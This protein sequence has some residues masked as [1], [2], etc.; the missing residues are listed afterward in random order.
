MKVLHNSKYFDKNCFLVPNSL[1][2][3]VVYKC[4]MLPTGQD[5]KILH[6]RN[7]SSPAATACLVIGDAVEKRAMEVFGEADS[8]GYVLDGNGEMVA[9]TSTCRL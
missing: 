1:T 2:G 4:R 5:G 7:A 3:R 6:V 8:T 9:A